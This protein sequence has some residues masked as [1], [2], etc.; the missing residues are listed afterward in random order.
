MLTYMLSRESLAIVTLDLYSTIQRNATFAN[1]CSPD[2]AAQKDVSKEA[3]LTETNGS[4]PVTPVTPAS[5][6][7]LL[8]GTESW[9][10]S[11][12]NPYTSLGELRPVDLISFAHQIAKGMVSQG[13]GI[14]LH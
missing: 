11:S 6:C 3:N 14:C 7:P 13:T 1:L 9:T 8:N 12:E 4:T 2:S 10:D 5:N